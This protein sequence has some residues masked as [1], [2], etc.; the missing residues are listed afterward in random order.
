MLQSCERCFGTMDCEKRSRLLQQLRLYSCIMP[1]LHFFIMSLCYHCI[2][3]T[4]LY[5]T[6]VIFLPLPLGGEFAAVAYAQAQPPNRPSSVRCPSPAN[7]R[8]MYIECVGQ[9]FDTIEETLTKDWIEL[10]TELSRRGITPIASYTTQLM[11]NTSGGQ[12]QGFTYSGTLQA[13]ILWDLYKLLHVPGLAFN[14]DAHWA[15][16]QNLSNDHIGNSLQVQSAYNS[17]GNGTNNLILGEIYVQQQLL[18]NSLMIAAGR[19]APTS[20]FATMPVLTNYVNAAINAVP[21]S[22]SINDATFTSHPPGVEWG[23]QALYNITPALQVAS[24]VF[25][26]NASAAAGGKGGLDF[27]FQQGNQGVL[28]VAQVTYLFNHGQ[29]DTGLPGQYALGGFYDSSRFASLSNPNST[30]SGTYNLY[31]M[32]QQMVY[33]DGDASSTKGLTVWG[34]AAIAPTTSVNP[35]PYF[36]GAGLSYQGLIAGRDNDIAAVGFIHGIFSQYIPRTTA[37][38]V[39]EANYQITIYRWLSITPDMQYIIRPSGSSAISNAFVIG[40][41]VAMNF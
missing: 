14:M 1:I 34:E 35:M 29:G 8:K 7:P 20:T 15:T 30:K 37:E 40:T 31:G 38:T 18:H 27:A 17:P 33:R 19:L 16:G 10:R 22:L 36:V 32:L 2:L 24:G 28:S 21:G 41:Q 26:T 39:L 3:A 4:F 25:N 11:G 5:S 6:F 23:A 12:S 13:S 9:P